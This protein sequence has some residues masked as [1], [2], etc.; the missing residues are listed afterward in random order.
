MAEAATEEIWNEI[1]EVL[2]LN[3]GRFHI[4]QLCTRKWYLQ[5]MGI[6]FPFLQQE[7]NKIRSQIQSEQ[8]A[9]DRILLI[10]TQEGVIPEDYLSEIKGRNIVIADQETIMT[11]IQIIKELVEQALQDAEEDEF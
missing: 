4:K 9:I 8:A 10:L 1:N 6:L 11:L 5:A 3:C 7:W 2:D